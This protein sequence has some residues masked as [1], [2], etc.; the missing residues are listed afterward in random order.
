MGLPERVRDYEIWG[1]LGEGGMSQVWLAKHSVLMIPV[2]Y[3][4]LTLPTKRI[5]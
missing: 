3:T 1:L 2:S 5:V 4:H